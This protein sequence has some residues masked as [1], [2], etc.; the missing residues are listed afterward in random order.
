[1]AGSACTKLIFAFII[2]YSLYPLVVL[3]IG[4]TGAI[5][6]KN[7]VEFYTP[8]DRIVRVLV[9]VI[10]MGLSLL[11]YTSF[12]V[13]RKK[14]RTTFFLYGVIFLIISFITLLFIPA[15]IILTSN[16]PFNI[17]DV[18]KEDRN[19][20]E[21][22][23]NC[24][25]YTEKEDYDDSYTTAIKVEAYYI[26]ADCAIVENNTKIDLDECFYENDQ[27]LCTTLNLNIGWVCKGTSNIGIFLTFQILM[28]IQFIITAIF[29]ISSFY[30]LF[31]EIKLGNY[32]E[33]EFPQNLEPDI[34]MANTQVEINDSTKEPN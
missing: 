2:I 23:N 22:E 26:F 30:I 18:G 6:A 27:L 4:I 17:W 11:S 28:F 10:G 13:I 1:M 21:I 31:I 19:K 25:Y 24:C 5:S 12:G 9:Y 32:Q 34:I 8:L 7:L 14:N 20:K 15:S 29:S 16:A 33:Q 3:A